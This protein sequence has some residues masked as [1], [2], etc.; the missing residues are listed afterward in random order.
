MPDTIKKRISLTLACL[1]ALAVF[2]GCGATQQV[3]APAETAQTSP[4]PVDDSVAW[5][6]YPM[7]TAFAGGDGSAQNPYQVANEGQLAFMAYLFSEDGYWDKEHDVLKHYSGAHFIQTSDIVINNGSADGW[8]SAA[9]EYAWL[10]IGSR[11]FDGVYDGNGFTVNGL[12]LYAEEG[13]YPSETGMFGSV[14]GGTLRNVVLLDSYLFSN[15]SHAGAIAGQVMN[16]VVEGCRSNA[17]LEGSAADGMNAAGGL[18][19]SALSGSLKNCVFEGSLC[20]DATYVGGIAGSL[21]RSIAVDC[22][23]SGSVEATD[24]FAY[25]GGIVGGV[26]SNGEATLENCSNSGKVIS[27][28]AY[29]GGI[30]GD[31]SVSAYTD[32]LDPEAPEAPGSI[33]LKG[34]MNTGSVTGSESSGS[35]GGIAGLFSCFGGELLSHM[36]M[37]NCEN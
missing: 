29:T 17:V 22:N 18:V 8:P 11:E 37:E 31:L 20:S 13:G 27:A 19:G 7:E 36:T 25:A 24:G 34:C 15:A 33:T 3:E 30:A 21:S 6:Y 12:Y 32:L 9:P 2:T 28:G 10:P 5:A 23:N 35:V 4:A 16:S 14:N 1:L 26:S